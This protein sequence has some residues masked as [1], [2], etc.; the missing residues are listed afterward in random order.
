LLPA[1]ALST[2]VRDVLQQGAAFPAGNVVT[3][4]VWAVAAI[5]FATRMFKWE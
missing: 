3:L 1:G 2:G 5:A 4:L